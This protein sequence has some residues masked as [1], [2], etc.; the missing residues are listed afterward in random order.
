MTQRIDTSA[1]ISQAEWSLDTFGPG[2]RAGVFRH[3]EEEVKEAEEHP[4]DVYEWDDLLI[5]V[6]DGAMRAGHSPEEIIRGYHAKMLRN[7]AR[8]WPD[9]PRLPPGRPINHRPSVD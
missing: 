4:E 8:T 1:L 2:F 9:R 6:F 3:I 5:L 7:K